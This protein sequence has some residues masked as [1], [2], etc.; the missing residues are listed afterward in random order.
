MEGKPLLDSSDSDDV[1]G[2]LIKNRSAEKETP[3]RTQ[4]GI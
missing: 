1:Q 4:V 3:N 2:D